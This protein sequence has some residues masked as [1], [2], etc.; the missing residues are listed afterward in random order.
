MAFI[1]AATDFSEVA[2]SAVHYAC[3]FAGSINAEIMVLHSFI[4]PV[5]FGDN[6]MPVMPIADAK[7]IAD[8]RMARLMEKLRNQ[9]PA[10]NISS[11][12]TYGD[13]V[14]SLDDITDKLQLSL[15]VIGNSGPEDDMLW[16]GSNL[17]S[18]IRTLRIPVLAVPM[19]YEFKMPANICYACDF[20]NMDI[21]IEHDLRKIAG[22]AEAQLHVLNI[23]TSEGAEERNAKTFFAD[24]SPVFHQIAK[25]DVN[26]AII[27][28][29]NENNMDWLIVVPHK[30]SFF[31]QLF[32]KSHTKAIIKTSPVPV[33]A[34]HEGK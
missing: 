2:D 9:Y 23:S 26:T 8:E 1:I 34:L 29:I 12:V 17:I 19:G 6:P 7:H 16:L 30:H 10:L 14:D 18:A 5:T 13:V 25:D 28:F 31:G 27:N 3:R 32:H 15:A 11:K 20:K 22:M 33:L 4:I 21:G 24:L